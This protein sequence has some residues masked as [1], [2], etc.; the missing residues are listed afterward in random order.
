[1]MEMNPPIIKHEY[2]ITQDQTG[3]EL[4]GDLEKT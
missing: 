4:I 3:T 2:N 1:M